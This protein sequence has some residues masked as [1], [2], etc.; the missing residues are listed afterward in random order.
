[1]LLPGL[2]LHQLLVGVVFVSA[3]LI[4]HVRKSPYLENRLNTVEFFSLFTTG[5]MYFSGTVLQICTD[6]V[7]KAHFCP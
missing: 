4:V 2:L 1:M 3:M 6:K 7:P 5:F